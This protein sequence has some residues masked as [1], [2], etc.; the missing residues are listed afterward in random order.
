MG[1]FFVKKIAFALIFLLILANIKLY[2]SQE[3]P[4]IPNKKIYS[5]FDLFDSKVIAC[6]IEAKGKY[7]SAI[8][9]LDNMEFESKK[10]ATILDIN[11]KKMEIDK[12]FS[13]GLKQVLLRAEDKGGAMATIR[14]E[15]ERQGLNNQISHL[16][17]SLYYDKPINLKQ[18]EGRLRDIFMRL[19][20]KPQ[21][22]QCI[23]SVK[24]G[25]FSQL[26]SEQMEK[27]IGK[28]L[29]DGNFDFSSRYNSLED[30]TYLSIASNP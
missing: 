12:N 19:G 11:Q 24:D 4:T 5:T 9:D 30:K 23:D 26:K 28:F 15:S 25:R 2:H 10:I 16:M 6:C 17:L 22:S 20:I 1:L 13:D 7:K 3:N 27:S 21:F 14:I 8:N 18:E 29:G